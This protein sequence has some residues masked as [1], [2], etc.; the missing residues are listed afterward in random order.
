MRDYFSGDIEGAA[1]LAAEDDYE[2]LPSAT[3]ASMDDREPVYSPQTQE[4][5]DRVKALYRR[6]VQRSMDNENTR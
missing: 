3:E 2:D 6:V 1:H 5:V 4:L